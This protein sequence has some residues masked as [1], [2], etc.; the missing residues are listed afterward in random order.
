MPERDSISQRKALHTAP[1]DAV[2]DLMENM[3]D[4]HQRK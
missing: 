1:T 3:Q 2:A 4:S